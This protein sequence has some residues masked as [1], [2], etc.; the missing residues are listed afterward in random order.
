MAAICYSMWQSC[1]VRLAHLAFVQQGVTSHPHAVSHLSFHGCQM[2]S[3]E[4]CCRDNLYR[5]I[6]HVA[7]LCD[8]VDNAQCH[9]CFRVKF[10]YVSAKACWLHSPRLWLWHS[11]SCAHE[12][13]FAVYCT[14]HARN[15]ERWVV[16]TGGTQK[17]LKRPVG[18]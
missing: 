15:F 1:S 5:Q 6:I 8:V 18:Q 10:D 2:A 9:A 16:Q 11:L 7:Y 14:T 17:L 4:A 13:T 12:L 3:P